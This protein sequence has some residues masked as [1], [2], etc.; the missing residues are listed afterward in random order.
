MLG[1]RPG[2]PLP[3]YDGSF[4]LS[5]NPRGLEDLTGK[6]YTEIAPRLLE[7]WEAIRKEFAAERKVHDEYRTYWVALVLDASYA[8]ERDEERRRAML[9]SALEMLPGAG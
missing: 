9:E 6:P 1:Q 3:G 7:V 2:P 5:P 8:Y 4:S